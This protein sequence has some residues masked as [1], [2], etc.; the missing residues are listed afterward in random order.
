MQHC[1]FGSAAVRA[2]D[3]DQ[4][5]LTPGRGVIKS[6]RSTQPFFPPGLV[7][8]V[9]ALLAGVKTECVRFACVGWQVTLC[10]PIYGE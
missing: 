2:S 1:I 7:N 10:D 3:F 4:A 5:G 9:P 8:R 6:P